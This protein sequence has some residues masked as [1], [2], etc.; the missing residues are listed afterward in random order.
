MHAMFFGGS[1]G[2][3]QGAW[4]SEIMKGT[5]KGTTHFAGVARV[6]FLFLPEGYPEV[7]IITLTVVILDSKHP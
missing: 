4:S 3:D 2:E 7:I 5:L 1:K 6:D